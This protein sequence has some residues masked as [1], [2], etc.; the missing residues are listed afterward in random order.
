MKIKLIIILILTVVFNTAVASPIAGPKESICRNTLL[1]DYGLIGDCYWYGGV[2]DKDIKKAKQYYL[3]AAS[4]NNEQGEYAKIR[5]IK[6]LLFESSEPLE[7]SMG[8]YILN[9]FSNREDVKIVNKPE[10]DGDTGGRGVAR[11]YLGVY[12]AG[13]EKHK[14]AEKYF[15]KSLEDNY[16]P[17]AYAL[18]YLKGTNKPLSALS[19]KEAQGL[20]DEGDQKQ[21]F[22]YY[23]VEAERK[24]Y[25]CWLQSQVDDSAKKTSFPVNKEQVER[26]LKQYGPCE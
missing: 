14:A 11:Y 21:Q 6:T 2:F 12:L 25:S 17:S 3:L 26:L 18:A 19:D 20:I 4:Y 23:W 9:D 15:K 7:N 10:Y 24:G 1:P 13:R 22:F 16:Y 5:A 8:L